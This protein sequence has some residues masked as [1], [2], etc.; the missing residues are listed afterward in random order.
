MD[1]ESDDEAGSAPRLQRSNT[2]LSPDR[3][4]LAVADRLHGPRA[5]RVTGEW[6]G[7]PSTLRSASD[8]CVTP[9]APDDRLT[10]PSRSS[11]TRC[12]REQVP[13]SDELARGYHGYADEVLRPITRST[14]GHVTTSDGWES[15]RSVN[16]RV[17]ATIPDLVT[18]GA[19]VWITGYHF[20]PLSELVQSRVS[21]GTFL[22]HYWPEPWPAW[23]TL[24]LCPHVRSTVEGLLSND[25]LAFDTPRYRDNFLRAVGELFP[26]A[27]VDKGAK[28]V[29]HDGAPTAVRSLPRG[30]AVDRV[31]EL[32]LSRTAEGFVSRFRDA[33]GIAA[34]RPT[35][36]A[37][38]GSED[39]AGLSHCLTTLEDLWSDD[40]PKREAFTF[41]LCD[42]TSRSQVSGSDGGDGA[43]PRLVERINRR[44]GT[45]DW[46]PVVAHTK[47]FT[48]GERYALYRDATVGVASSVH[49]S[50]IP[51]TAE[52]VASQSADPGVLLL[53][54]R[55]E[56]NNRFDEGALVFSPFDRRS[57]LERLDEGLLLG[58][59]ARRTR[60]TR[61][62]RQ[63]RGYDDETWLQYVDGTIRGI[64]QRRGTDRP[65]T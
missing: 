56:T 24:R 45:V 33:H 43:V 47:D 49:E 64:E 44:F 41:V 65:S 50:G 18:D 20:A 37:L 5:P 59:E 22:L 23:D 7:L 51:E 17:A 8:V 63:V 34:D 36:V 52:F 46:Q 14:L 29:V 2:P 48:D 16:E 10:E 55:T 60:G 57:F 61:L 62:S 28:Q 35:V 26:D 25:L 12:T 15:Y 38:D 13:I 21:E 9:T 19:V 54:S 6:R 40:A 27:G 11:P 3:E 4:V 1:R 58:P 42:G 30:I 53:S 32:A 31:Q 39:T